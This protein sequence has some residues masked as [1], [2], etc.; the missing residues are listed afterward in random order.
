MRAGKAISSQLGGLSKF[1]VLIIFYLGKRR[2]TLASRIMD[3]LGDI[4]EKDTFNA[5]ESNDNDAP[6]ANN[7]KTGFPELYRPKKISSWKERLRE[8]RAQRKDSGAK[9]TKKQQVATDAPLSEAKSIP[10]ENIKVLQEMTDDQIISE[11]PGPV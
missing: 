8:K 6:I 2:N 3:L 9:E 11:R 1:I 7:S 10:E 5:V 4:V